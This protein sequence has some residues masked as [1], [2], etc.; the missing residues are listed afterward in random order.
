MKKQILLV[1]NDQSLIQTL[2][3]ILE[4]DY[5]IVT[6]KTAHDAINLC[7]EKTFDLFIIDILLDDKGTRNGI[8]VCKHI[9][10][11]QKDIPILFI[12]IKHAI[13]YKLGAFKFGA[14]DYLC[15]PF[16]LLELNARIKALM[17]RGVKVDQQVV[18]IKDLELDLNAKKVS[19][20]GRLMSLRHKEYEILELLIKN[21]GS[22]VSRDQIIEQI[23][24]LDIPHGNTV[25]VH[26]KNL[27]EKVDIPF[28]EKLIKT[29]HSVGYI[30]E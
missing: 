10:Q 20:Q 11:T 9:R 30:V 15:K 12:S 2:T 26:I 23:W 27:R 17:R 28:N 7:T 21:R 6:S 25:D 13:N 5:E 8:D 29:V 4:K 14:D 19:R 24:N 1:E 18:R 22:V 16:S 3:R